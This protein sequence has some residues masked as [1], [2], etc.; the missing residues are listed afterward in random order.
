MR[1]EPPG[2]VEDQLRVV[3]FACSRVEDTADGGVAV[4]VEQVERGFCGVDA[5]PAIEG[6]VFACQCERC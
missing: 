3:A 6:L 1:R 5:G 4:D 2:V